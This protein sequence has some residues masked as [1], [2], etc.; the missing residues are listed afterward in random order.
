MRIAPGYSDFTRYPVA[1]G[2]SLLAIGTTIASMAGADLSP[3]FEN[4]MIRRGEYWRL[5]TCILPHGGVMHLIFNVY[6]MWVLGTCV[7]ETFGPL[8][9]A[10]LVVVLGVGSSAYEF[11]FLDGG[12]GLSGVV[13]GLFGLIWVLGSY[14][15]RFSDVID[16]RTIQ[17][18]VAWFFFCI[19]LTALNV[20]PVANFAH[21][22]GAL[23]GAL[24]GFN[25][26]ETPY[27]KL[28]FLGLMAVFVFGVWG[29]T[30]G[31]PR[32]N[33]SADRGLVE[34]QWAYEAL[35]NDRNEEASIWF[36][37]AVAYRPRQAGYWFDLGI[38]YERLGRADEAIASFQKA[39]DLGDEHAASA[40]GEM[41]QT[42]LGGVRKSESQAALW[43]RKAADSG[44]SDAQNALSW[45]YSSS[46]D[47]AVR[48]PVAALD[49]AR[50][51]LASETGEPDAQRLDTLAQAYFVN[52]RFEDASK[53]QTQALAAATPEDKEAFKARLEKYRLAALAAPSAALKPKK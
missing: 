44:D 43:Y 20:M 31:R 50:R 14:D 21:G 17:I 33:L 5:L 49:F 34:G 24:V 9:T 41:Y 40:I 23:L 22:T 47:P 37:D 13:Y 3:L 4:P 18:F 38:A 6:W 8:R 7:E 26:V 52:N 2:T 10:L 29:A 42:G 1:A 51:S 25:T 39:L 36:K 15:Q 11:A 19:I 46:T 35:V 32:L 12:T 48:N 45:L 27:R 16:A 30:A 28:A 53:T